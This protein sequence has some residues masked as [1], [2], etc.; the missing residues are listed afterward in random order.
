[1]RLPVNPVLRRFQNKP[2]QAVFK[3]KGLSISVWTIV[4][5][6]SFYEK[7]HVSFRESLLKYPIT[8]KAGGLPYGTESILEQ[9]F[10]LQILYNADAGGRIYPIYFAGQSYP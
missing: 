10:R 7:S 8:N 9:R 3:R 4:H 2:R 6:P 5:T 1:M